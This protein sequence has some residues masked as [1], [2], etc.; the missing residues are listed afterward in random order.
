[1]RRKWIISLCAGGTVL[2]AAVLWQISATEADPVKAARQEQNGKGAPDSPLPIRQ[3]VLFNTG[4]GYFQ[5]E[6]QVDGSARVELTFPSSDM[7]D[8]LKSL[9][10]QDGGGGK[11]SAV[12][13]DSYD[14][15][16][17]TLRSFAIDLS[18]NPTFGQILNQARG[19]KIEVVHL[20]KPE[21]KEADKK[22]PEKKPPLPA[23]VT[24]TIVG[25]EAQA[26]PGDAR[27]VEILNLTTADGLQAI[28]LEQVVSIRFLNQLLEK[29][30]QRALQVLARA[31]TRKRRRSA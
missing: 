22:T 15:I 9:I 1:M 17:K 31:M 21:K 16:E 10:L 4:V 3:V 28:P 13:Y 20:G 6:G 23:H 29:E 18:A 19:E 12:N 11:I 27:E 7:N 14:P 8:L 5:R 2:L 30:F 25:M 24:G 26:R